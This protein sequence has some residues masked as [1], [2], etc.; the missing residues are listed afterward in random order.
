MTPMAVPK[1]VV[2]TPPLVPPEALQRLALD[3][4]ADLY[5]LD[6]PAPVAVKQ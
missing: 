4:R 5:S 2:G 3:G 1:E 6:G